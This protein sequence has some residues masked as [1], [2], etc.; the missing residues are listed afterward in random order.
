[1][2]EACRHA[3]GTHNG[4]LKCPVPIAFGPS[5][6]S[7]GSRDG[8]EWRRQKSGPTRVVQFDLYNI[9]YCPRRRCPLSARTPLAGGGEY[10]YYY[11]HVH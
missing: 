7:A 4:R 5:R 3:A 11:T 6:R 2:R 8:G 9:L 10:A 1:M